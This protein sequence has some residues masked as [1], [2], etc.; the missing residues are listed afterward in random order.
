L[1]PLSVAEPVVLV[2]VKRSQRRSWLHAG[3]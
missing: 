2:V 3:P 1:I